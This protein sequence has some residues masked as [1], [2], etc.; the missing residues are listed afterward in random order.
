L[1]IQPKR[2]KPQKG[3]GCTFKVV[4]MLP[5]WNLNVDSAATMR[6][7]WRMAGEPWLH[8]VLKPHTQEADMPSSYLDELEALPNVEV[9]GGMGSVALIEGT[10]AMM[11]M[12]TDVAIEALRQGKYHLDPTYLY[13][14]T[15]LLQELGAGWMVHSDDELIDALKRLASGE[16]PPYGNEQVSKAI[17]QLVVES[18][19]EDDVLGR[20]VDFI[21]GGWKDYPTYEYQLQANGK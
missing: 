18:S 19:P 12:G 10:D 7:L 2:F 15:T 8:L 13:D 6:A 16:R 14:N 4:F 9:A 5:Q 3:D 1:D 17:K 11:G 20:H 21:L